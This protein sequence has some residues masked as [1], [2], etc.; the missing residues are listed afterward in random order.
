MYSEVHMEKHL[1]GAFIIIQN[2]LNEED[3]LCNC[4]PTLL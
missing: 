3:A 4:C 2:G 1:S